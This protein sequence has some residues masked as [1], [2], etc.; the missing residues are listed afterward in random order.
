MAVTKLITRCAA[1]AL[2]ACQLSYAVVL[3]E[4]RVDALYHS[5]DGGG[6]TIDGPSVLVRKNFAETVSI[7]A[8]YYVDNVSSASIDV[9]TSGA[10]KYTE[11]R[12]EYSV[13]ATYLVD[14]SL[15]SA[16]ITRSDENDYQAETSYFSISQDMF[17]DLTNISF[18]YARGN[19]IVGQNGNDDFEENIDRQ[20]YRFG[21]SQILTKNLIM[22]FN[23]ENISDEGFLNNPYRNYRFL[24]NPLD[25]SQG[26]QLSQEVYPSTRTSDAASLRLAYYLPYRAAIKAEYRFF[27][28][29]WG[30]EAKTYQLNYTHPIGEHWVFDI[31]YRTYEQTQADFYSDLFLFASQDEK[32][33]RARDKELSDFENTTIGLGIS[34]FLPSYSKHIAKSKIA[35][36]WDYIE[37]DYNNFTNLDD[38]SAAIGEEELYQFDANVIKFYFSIWY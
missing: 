23:Y 11:E 33:Y 29:D 18:G 15:L 32:D 13:G 37:F 5:Y 28:D 31:K 3:P 6:V 8:N 4:E 27:T 25:A 35:L 12:T 9:T 17:G 14:K 34:Y 7:S 16:G 20:N 26:Y 30:I 19:D 38:D 21:L 24:I 22:G 2:A 1:L 10:S 36:Q